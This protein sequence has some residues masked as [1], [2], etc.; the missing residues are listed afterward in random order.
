[1]FIRNDVTKDGTITASEKVLV[2]LYNGQKDEKI[3]ELRL[4]K[5]IEINLLQIFWVYGTPACILGLNYI[6]LTS[7]FYGGPKLTQH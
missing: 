6:G 4:R 3:D 7:K 1:M 5:S 2:S